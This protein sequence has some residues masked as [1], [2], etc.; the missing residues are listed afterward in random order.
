MAGW[1]VRS[2]PT[3]AL[4]LLLTALLAVWGAFLVPLRIGGVAAP[5][6]VVVALAN[7]PLCRAGAAALGRRAGAGVPMVL[8]C[9]IAFA[10]STQRSEGDL[11]ITGSL[12]GLAF[13]LVGLLA[14]ALAVG[15]YRP[16]T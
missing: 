2:V 12:R 10:L 11:V 1:D 4:V 9:A 3:F 14:A 16:P 8:W 5:V 13:L 6:G 15:G 7:L